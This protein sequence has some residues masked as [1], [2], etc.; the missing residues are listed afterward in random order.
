[1]IGHPIDPF[2]I[3]LNR[4]GGRIVDRQVMECRMKVHRSVKTRIEASGNDGT[5]EYTPRIRCW[6]DGTVRRLTREEW[7]AE[8]PVHFDWVD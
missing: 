7:L 4:S 2:S 3:S 5:K 8:P 6:V 1:V